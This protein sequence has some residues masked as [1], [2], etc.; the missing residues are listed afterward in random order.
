MKFLSQDENT[1]L[2]NLVILIEKIVAS[3]H[4]D[5]EYHQDEIEKH[6]TYL[7]QGVDKINPYERRQCGINDEVWQ[8]VIKGALYFLNKLRL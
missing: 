3:K 8:E 4:L 5:K 6:L 2:I 1:P 7:I